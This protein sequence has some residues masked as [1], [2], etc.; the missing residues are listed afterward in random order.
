MTTLLAYLLQSGLCLASLWL[1]YRIF[2]HR[3]TFFTM[4]RIYLV[5]AVIL[6]MVLPL[7]P[8]RFT[9]GGTLT[10]FMVM[11]EPVVVT[12]ETISTVAQSHLAWFTIA[13]IVYFTGVSIFTVRFLVQ[14]GQLLVLVHR[15]G[16]THR[17]GS[18]LVLV[19]RGYSPFSF[20]NLI[21]IRQ[22]YAEDQRL[23]A[24]IEHERIHI[25]QLHTADLVVTELLTIVQWFNPFAWLLQ[26]S[27]KTVHEYLADEG[28]LRKG[29]PGDDYRRLIFGQALGMQVNN[30]TN[31]FNVSLIKKRMIMMTQSRSARMAGLKAI[32]AL[33][34]LFA[35]VLFFSAG[36]LTP[37]SAQD[38][39][40][41]V[42]K[43]AQAKA[44]QAN[45]TSEPIYGMDAKHVPDHQPEYPGGMDEMVKFLV[46]NIKYPE[47]AKK[48]GTVGTVFVNFVVNTDGT[49]SDIKVMR[50]IGNGC[51]EEAW[52]V[53]KMMPKWK[54]GYMN[55]G[56]AVRVMFVLPVRFSLENKEVTPVKVAPHK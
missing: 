15:T 26:R 45:E 9:F 43:E 20:F 24:V 11:L 27:V 14:I 52:R 47:A 28:V 31:N 2:L 54:P 13:G 33:P 44:S 32:F 41:P 10:P 1:V 38:K 12:P 5:S 53:V 17:N 49:L 30:L 36:S 29:I 50:G 3:D 48:A 34:V 4:N 46:S 7:F 51:D 18:N 39:G 21:F 22:E 37:L 55:D 6:S 19:D 23:S 25:R 35:V 16:I 42:E 56:K 8:F 40:K